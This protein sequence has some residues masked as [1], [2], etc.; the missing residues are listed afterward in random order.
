MRKTLLTLILLGTIYSLSF[1]RVF[2]VKNDGNDL[3]D[4]LSIE[5][6]WKTWQKAFDTAI[7]G[8]TVYF[9][10][11]VYYSTSPNTIKNSGTRS[12][13]ILFAGYPNDIAY[14]NWPILDCSKHVANWTK[15]WNFYNS[16]IYLDKV[17]FIH[18]KNL[19]VRN[20]F[21]RDA[22]LNGAITA[23]STANITYE[24]L[25]VHDVGQ[26][27]YWHTSGAWSKYDSIYA[28]DVLGQKPSKIIF[29]QPDT[30]R[31][32][33]CDTWN[34]C[35]TLS[36][37]NNPGNGGDAWKVIS[38]VGN[39]Y[40]WEGCRAWNYSDD[41]FD[42]NKGERIFKNC[43]V[44]ASKKYNDFGIEG[45]GFKT[46]SIQEDM[47]ESYNNLLK[48]PHSKRL[49]K[50]IGC[51]AIFCS[52][53]GFYHGLE[54]DSTDNAYWINNTAY[55]CG[56]GFGSNRFG[57]DSIGDVFR[58]NIS[59][60][61]TRISAINT[62]YDLAVLY[63]KYAESNN[64]WTWQKSYPC[65]IDREIVSDD[66]FET[67]DSLTLVALFTA[68]RKAD[69]SLPSVRPL[70]LKSTSKLNDLGTVIP[71]SDNINLTLPHYNEPAIGYYEYSPKPLIEITKYPTAPTE[72][73]FSVE[74]YSFDVSNIQT[75]VT[76]SKGET[77][78]TKSS[79]SVVGSGNKI[80]INISD[81]P[82]DLYTVKID[83]GH[84]TDACNI[85][86]VDPLKLGLIN[87]F[88]N[89]TVDLFAIE[90]VCPIGKTVSVKVFNESG[91]VVL[92]ESLYNN[93]ESNKFILNLSS[94]EA[95]NHKVELND[96]SNTITTSVFKQ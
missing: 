35:D 80:P 61:S 57:L 36:Y 16:G 51:L 56:T 74:Y 78:S 59:Y 54:S 14:N 64:S 66:D 2:Y 52:G 26:R 50:T 15:S 86:K 32:I 40:I 1:S 6:A 42:P 21:Q 33:N 60:K 28:V 10:G 29:P 31:W 41:G 17:Q 88:P 65:F 22:V 67:L 34:C 13:P 81:L 9:K 8:D 62:P 79:T 77:V 27:G 44:M 87:S 82:A 30:T 90:F 58:N 84:S 92:T 70:Q 3:K 24:L 96:G 37:D 53:T 5:N 18:L 68:P 20:V 72:G 47:H 75:T 89:P 23:N 43:W 94:L 93:S 7:A 45:N 83:D 4:G 73:S 71:K 76:N 48:T 95:G 55:K 19:E 11:G 63:T 25:R 38:Y 12:K 85:T 49:V 91:K 39:T 46:S 69:G